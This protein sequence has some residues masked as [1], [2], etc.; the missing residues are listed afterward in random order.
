MAV[1]QNQLCWIY[2]AL[3]DECNG[4]RFVGI[5]GRIGTGGVFRTPEGHW[6]EQVIYSDSGA[7]IVCKGTAIA[8]PLFKTKYIK[9][10]T[11]H[12]IYRADKPS[13]LRMIQYKG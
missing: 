3:Q 9:F 10:Q 2:A 13:S 6:T 12:F 1:T 11:A 7:P 5:P 8:F 4:V